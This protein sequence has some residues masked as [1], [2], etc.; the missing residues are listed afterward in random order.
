MSRIEVRKP[1]WGRAICTIFRAVGRPV[2]SSLGR[3][4]VRRSDL[5][6]VK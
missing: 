3:L 2:P 6:I 1:W 5:P 4:I